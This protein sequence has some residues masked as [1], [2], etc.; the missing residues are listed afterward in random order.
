MQPQK[1][2]KQPNPVK[3]ARKRQESNAGWTKKTNAKVFSQMQKSGIRPKGENSLPQTKTPNKK[4]RA[5][6]R[7]IK[8][9]ARNNTRGGKNKRF[10]FSNNTPQ[11]RPRHPNEGGKIRAGG[12]KHAT[13]PDGPP[14]VLQA[15]GGF[16]RVGKSGTRTRGGLRTERRTLPAPGSCQ[17][18]QPPPQEWR[19]AL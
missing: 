4:T 3:R 8:N 1:R 18:E 15:L 13:N 7:G 6:K 19:R 12:A 11:M 5:N 9:P 17:R 16:C 14:E 10:K 2:E